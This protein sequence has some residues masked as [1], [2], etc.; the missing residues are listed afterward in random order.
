MIDIILNVDLKV[1]YEN[2]NKDGSK[3]VTNN[4]CERIVYSKKENVK[5]DVNYKEEE[6]QDVGKDISRDV[7]KG[8][9]MTLFITLKFYISCR[10]PNTTLFFI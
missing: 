1:D 2:I 3:D 9:K 6:I 10:K 5:V 7:S 8:K 4:V